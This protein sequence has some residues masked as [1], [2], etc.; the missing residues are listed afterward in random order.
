MRT[1]R[2]KLQ[3]GL[4]SQQEPFHKASKDTEAAVEASYVV[5]ALISK[6]GKTF[7][8]GQFL[9]DCMFYVT[10]ILCPEK[11]SLL[12][13]VPLLANTAAERVNDLS[14]NIYEHLRHK[15]PRFIAYFMMLD[16]STDNTD[17]AQL[18]VFIRGV[19]G[20]FEVTEE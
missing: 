3:R 14:D 8:E 9:K 11:N 19:D 7:T 2:E 1:T 13:N 20:K 10:E 5:S 6:T 17:N 15:V 4:V 18:A 12:N 16:E